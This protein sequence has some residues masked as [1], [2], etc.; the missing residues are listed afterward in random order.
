MPDWLIDKLRDPRVWFALLYTIFR[1]VVLLLQYLEDRRHRNLVGVS[2]AMGTNGTVQLEV[3]NR[4]GDDLSVGGVILLR[5]RSRL[6]HFLRKYL[7]GVEKWVSMD[8]VEWV[9]PDKKLKQVKRHSNAKPRYFQLKATSD[10]ERKELA[11][12][13]SSSWFRQTKVRIEIGGYRVLSKVE[14]VGVPVV[15]SKSAKQYVAQSK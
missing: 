4:T 12:E 14:F 8:I 6:R 5:D 7:L 13:L 3:T 9:G 2:A 10:M 1:S 15:P 11:S